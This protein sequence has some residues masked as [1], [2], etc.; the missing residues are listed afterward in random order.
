M[1]QISDYI[2]SE[3]AKGLTDEVIGIN[4]KSAGWTAEQIDGAFREANTLPAMRAG[5]T[6]SPSGPATI[7][8]TPMTAATPWMMYA[9]FTIVGLSALVA[10]WYF[11]ISPRLNTEQ[12]GVAEN[13]NNQSVQ[14]SQQ[15]PKS[16]TSADNQTETPPV[17]GG[18]I[19]EQEGSASGQCKNPVTDSEIQKIFG[20]TYAFNAQ[21]SENGSIAVAGLD[22]CYFVYS[23]SEGNVENVS[24]SVKR[25]TDA[26]HLDGGCTVRPEGP[27][28]N[29]KSLGVGR[30]SLYM[31]S[32]GAFSQ[33][34][35]AI[36]VS[37]NTLFSVIIT[38]I[39][40]GVTAESLTSKA[41][42]LAQV[43]YN[44]LSK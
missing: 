3:R 24:V 31:V 9:M 43:V 40:S 1:S 19:V 32:T 6:A 15:T 12:A 28:E 10:V 42:G 11:V 5:Q 39:K 26:Q 18:G 33:A 17:N 34:Q 41:R 38:T 35:S 16:D 23:S 29:G 37:D 8:A 36:E 2:R 30:N 13:K 25:C 7:V 44:E 21:A 27:L 4:L 14:S 22:F 20:P